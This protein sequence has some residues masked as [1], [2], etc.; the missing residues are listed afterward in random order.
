MK[1]LS[2]LVQWLV[3]AAFVGS[4][5]YIVW[6]PKPQPDYAPDRWQD[7]EGLTVLS[8]SGIA[9][10][11]SA[12]YPSVKLLEA[13]L[14]ALRDA[15]YQ[16]VRPED[17]LDYLQER[18]PL[19]RKALLLIFEGGRKEA[20]IRATPVLQRTG[21]MAV[22]AV[23]TSVM[24][25]W[26]SFYLKPADIGRIARIPQWQVGSM[27][28]QAVDPIPDST[29][30]AHS[31]FLA[32]RIRV[33]GREESSDE[34][35][36]RILEDYAHSSHLLEKAAGRPPLLYLYPYGEAGQHAGADPLAE[37]VNRS[38]VTR[39]FA[40]AFI[41]ASNAFNGPGSDPF[42]LTRLRVPGDWTPEQLLAD[43]ASSQP[44]RRPQTTLDTARDWVFER[45]A[46]LQ[47]ATLSITDGAAAW[48]RGTEAW[49]DAD[50]SVTLDPATEATASLYARY[51]SVRSWLRVAVDAQGL[52]VQERLGGRLYTLYRRQASGE[53]P[54]ARQIRLRIRNNRAWVWL[55][56]E[57]VAENLP[58]APETRRGR[59]G[60][61]SERGDVCVIG[62]SARPLP[63]RWVL[64]NSIRLIPD[65]E[66]DQVQAIL[67]NWFKAS[68][69]ETALARTAQQDL[70]QSAV[71]GI[72]CLPLLSG[73]AELD[74][75]AARAWAAA[76]DEELIRSDVKMLVS[77]LAVQGPALALAA[78]LR[79]RKYRVA[80]VLTPA[81]VLEWGRLIAQATSTEVIVI[82]GFGAEA[83]RAAT[84][85][86]PMI[87][88]SRLALRE[89]DDAALTPDIATA[90]LEEWN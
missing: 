33:N 3:I 52:R 51:T 36:E 32:Q 76:I 23:P 90:L 4:L 26:G 37:S 34:F 27:G 61:G 21:F 57:L 39:H 5:A 35:H 41:G 54:A 18:A 10:K 56:G 8:Y 9:R 53:A 84:W 38:A 64:A 89:A 59:I 73:G 88:P 69:S 50:L 67:P 28:H 29:D 25:Q 16:T 63:S 85:L 22:I 45:Q 43:L 24:S 2:I 13:H 40:L 31:R 65:T 72:Q 62:F 12:R 55:Q 15:G 82:N 7:W 42:A 6:R 48:L 83:Q 78:E 19:P 20:F 58:L 47:D 86:L 60:L 81:Q 44:R 87:P 49:T 30:E 74:D 14:T 66:R 1:K 80:H 75:E 77:G 68:D 70:L 71:T 17:V 11:N 79:N 46:H